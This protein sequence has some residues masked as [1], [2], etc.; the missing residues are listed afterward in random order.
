MLTLH[1]N[2][3]FTTSCHCLYTRM[4][5]IVL[6]YLF[7]S[8]ALVTILYMNSLLESAV[9][10]KNNNDNSRIGPQPNGQDS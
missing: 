8:Y 2:I 5:I 7:N 1:L 4:Y 3:Y 10:L 6:F 9:G